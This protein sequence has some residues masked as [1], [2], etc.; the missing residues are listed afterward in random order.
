[1]S[2]WH[3]F[4]LCFGAFAGVVIAGVAWAVWHL[5]EAREPSRVVSHLLDNE[6]Q[7]D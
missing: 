7:N 5:L 1:M 2:H 3:I 6:N 4:F